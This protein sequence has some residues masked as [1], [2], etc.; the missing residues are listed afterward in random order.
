MV[1][2][3]DC[4]PSVVMYFI[5]WFRCLCGSLYNISAFTRILLPPSKVDLDYIDLRKQLLRAKLRPSCYFN[6]TRVS[7]LAPAD[8]SKKW[9]VCVNLRAE[10]RVGSC[11]QFQFL[12][13]VV[14]KDSIW[15]LNFVRYSYLLFLTTHLFCFQNNIF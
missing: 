10:L 2:A 1:Q 4:L 11:D 7:Y 12:S 5:R 8:P 15:H 14:S 3:D 13:S 9:T 6:S